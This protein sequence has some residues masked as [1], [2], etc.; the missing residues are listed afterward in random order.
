MHRSCVRGLAP[1]ERVDEQGV[2]TYASGEREQLPKCQ[3]PC[4][5]LHTLQP[6]VLARDQRMGGIDSEHADYGGL[7]Y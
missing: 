2:V 3:Y 4:L 7:V 5:N 6:I 1:G